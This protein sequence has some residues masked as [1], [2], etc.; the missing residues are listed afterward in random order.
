[1]RESLCTKCA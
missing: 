1:L